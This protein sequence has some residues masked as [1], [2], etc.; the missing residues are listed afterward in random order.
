MRSVAIVGSGP[1]GLY[2]AEALLKASPDVRVD[3]IDRLPTPFGLV[4]SGVAPDHQSTKGVARLLDRVLAKPDVAFFGGVEL[5]RDVSLDELRAAYDAVAIATG[6]ACDRTLGIP[7][8]SLPGVYASGRFVGWYNHHPDHADVDLAGVRTA[9]AIGAGN[10]ALDVARILAKTPDEFAGSDL[11]PEVSAALAA[12]TLERIRIVGRRA[13]TAMKFTA[14]ELLELRDLARAKTELGAGTRIEDLDGA[15][16]TALAE[17]VAAAD[18]TKPLSLVFDFGLVP[19]AF[20]G[21]GR[22][23]RVR[24]RAADGTDRV[25][26]AQLAVTCVGYETHGHD[27]ER[28]AGALRNVDGRIDAALYAV[29]WAKR[30]PSGTIPTNR[31]EAQLVA[32]T[33]VAD[34]GDASRNDGRARLTALLARRGVAYVGYD[35]WRRIDLSE[36]ARSGDA[37]VRRKWR[38]H[39]ALHAA[40]TAT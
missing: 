10:V 29:G 3:V 9:I 1:A 27:L 7:G 31:S 37:R 34:F 13:A 22:L 14:G 23:E 33:I 39:D 40:A 5:G 6:A 19:V 15:A 28:D 32:K 38:S 8:E 35:A 36:I 17:V 2:C 18:E 25:I 24:F 26:D 16:G 21:D 4:R 20:E 30:G 11:A 12:A